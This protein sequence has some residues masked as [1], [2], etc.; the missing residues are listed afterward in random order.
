MSE[1]RHQCGA[2]ERFEFVESAFIDDTSDHL[3]NIEGLMRIRGNQTQ[4]FVDV[5]TRRRRFS[6]RDGRRASPLEIRDQFARQAERV[7]VVLGEMIRDARAS[8][9]HI[10]AAQ[11]LGRDDFPGRRGDEWRAAKKNCPLPA[12]NDR[13]VAHRRNIGAAGRA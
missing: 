6:R 1:A 8:A 5:V 12:H 13:L 10:G 2:I 4:Q 11:F 3:S 7:G 9:M